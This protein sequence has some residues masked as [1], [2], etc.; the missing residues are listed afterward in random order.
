MPPEFIGQKL[1]GSA[2][3]VWALGVTMLYVLRKIT[4]PD[5]RGRQGHERQLYWMIADINRRSHHHHHP[6]NKPP[7]AVLQMQQWLGEVNDA[8]GNLDPRDKLHVLVSQ[9]LIL[10]PNKRITMAKVMSAL[11]GPVAE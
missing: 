7:S 3:D 1:R 6:S 10:S 11:Q 9:M 5:A 2:S 4:F 8:K